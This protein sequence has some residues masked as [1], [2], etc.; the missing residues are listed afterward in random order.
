VVVTATNTEGAVAAT[1]SQTTTVQAI[2]PTNTV[3]PTITGTVQAGHTLTVAT[4]T[5]S[6]STPLTY[7]YQW[8]DCNSSGAGC[9]NISGATASTY[10]LA[11]GDVGHTIVASVTASNASLA[12]G[13]SASAASPATTVVT[14]SPPVN[15]TAPAITGT[16]QVSSTLTA[17]SGSWSGTG[18]IT[19]GYQWL[20]CGPTGGSCANISGATATTYS[21]GVGDVGSEIEVTV[22]ASNSN[23]STPASSSATSLIEPATGTCGDSWIPA[24]SGTWSTTSN[25]S[26][27]STPSGS[28]TVCL[29]AGASPTV[30]STA[31]AD[32]IQGVDA[33][34]TLQS[35]SLSLTNGSD[36]SAIGTLQI[37][38]GTLT[39]S[40]SL[41]VPGTLAWTEG[42]IT[43]AGTVDLTSASTSTITPTKSTSLPT[44]NGTTLDNA[45]TLTVNCA[46]PTGT[47][48]ESDFVGV[49]GP[50]LNNTGTLNLGT[51]DSQLC[52][53]Q[54]GAGATSELIN[55]A[56]L[57]VTGD[58]FVAWEMQNATTGTVSASTDN[59]LLALAGGEVPGSTEAG[60]WSGDLCL[61]AGTFDF[62]NPDAMTDN[63]LEVGS[64]SGSGAVNRL[65]AALGAA[66]QP[67]NVTFP[68]VDWSATYLSE[69]SGTVSIGDSSNV[70]SFGTDASPGGAEVVGGSLTLISP[71]AQSSYLG[72]SGATGGSL[73]LEGEWSAGTNGV[74]GVGWPSS[75]GSTVT[76]DGTLSGTVI[77]GNDTTFNQNGTVIASDL[78]MEA[79]GDPVSQWPVVDGT[80]TTF[81]TP[82][83]TSDT[84]HGWCGPWVYGDIVFKQQTLVNESGG[85]GTVL[86]G[87]M[88]FTDDATFE[89]QGVL[90]TA[91]EL[92]A[93]SSELG[94]VYLSNIGLIG[95]DG[96]EILNTGT[97]NSD[98]ELFPTIPG[99]S[100]PSLVNDGTMID[101]VYNSGNTIYIGD[102]PGVGLNVVQWPYSGTG[103]ASS[104][105]VFDSNS[106]GMFGGSNPASPHQGT[107]SCGDPVVCA[108][109]DQTEQQTD[110]SLGGL[111]GLSLTRTYNSQL[112]ISQLTPGMFGYGW[113]SSFEAQLSINT[114]AAT[115]TVQ[116]PNGSTAGFTINSDGSFSPDQGVEAT[117]TQNAGGSY[118]Y[119]LPDQQ[120]YG[121]N[122]SGE[123][124]S[125][126]SSTGL[127]TNLA[128]NSSGQLTTVTAPS[129][130]QLTFTYNSAGLVATATDPAG[131]VV[132]YGY[133][134]NDNL[135]SVSDSAGPATTQWQ[136]A[137]DGEH[138]L[139]SMTDADGNATQIAYAAGRVVS[140]TDPLSRTTRW[141]YSGGQ[142]LVT[143]P[144][145]NVTQYLFN[146]QNEPVS[147]TKGYGTAYATTTT[148]TYNAA[149]EPTS[150]TD[151]NDQ[152]TTYGYDTAGNRT[153]ETDPDSHETTWTY[154]ANRN[155]LTE[156]LPSGKTTTTVYNS[157]SLPTSVAVSGSGVSTETSGMTYY[158]DGQLHTSTDP[159][160]KTTTYAYNSYGDL[161]SVTDPLG[162]RRPTATTPMGERR[163]WSRPRETSAERT[164]RTTPRA[165]PT[166]RW[167]I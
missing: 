56:T 53:L 121:F 74:L 84:L 5:W 40:G 79:V 166:T 112:A 100:P 30:S 90:I 103:S 106:S 25:W 36:S 98:D 136:F 58:S 35:G 145:G 101:N 26:T 139:T 126:T 16:D 72:S 159:R 113:T 57:N 116:Q 120:A 144:A 48:G 150:V 68:A 22:T 62:S 165:T 149:G 78:D 164:R 95:G 152:T 3:A 66:G 60:T 151:G 138:E 92:V 127:T 38:G 23:G 105:Y 142:T 122:S 130:R 154:D 11:T 51:S 125:E 89:N 8:E 109:G 111:G 47:Y 153:S 10:V 44:L 39:N 162:T 155:V 18:P 15:T 96:A 52:L 129:G 28:Q 71:A 141:S 19:Y 110:L 118:T 160:D 86:T 119:T 4:G 133:D 27:G 102:G 107:P 137:Y 104:A 61:L 49:D 117:L 161:A 81:I 9:T 54:Q 37:N 64:T 17:S 1:S 156:S 88:M 124:V 148:T 55:N 114:T 29:R 134:Y 75:S 12:G 42:T 97:I 85:C 82:T 2:A 32:S 45:G 50:V 76:N 132:S 146:S 65:L 143:S 20:R 147:T 41:T 91:P 158:A 93:S 115:A 123:L 7:T 135:I 157:Q 46:H 99:Q 167:G 69:S 80:G 33:T 24:G 83:A 21:L 87:P 14:G 13:G 43:G 77:L 67:P 131:L 140:Q 108:T 94:L 73:T 70:S 63:N 31:T 128:Y 59:P 34:V 6:G 163:R